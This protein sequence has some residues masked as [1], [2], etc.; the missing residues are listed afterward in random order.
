MIG[1][2][3]GRW[4]ERLE[5]REELGVRGRWGRSGKDCRLKETRENEWG[6]AGI[7]SRDGDDGSVQ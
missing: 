7:K 5:G 1:M 2:E 6:E 3:A 4:K